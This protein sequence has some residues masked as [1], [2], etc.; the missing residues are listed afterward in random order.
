MTVDRR[1]IVRHWSGTFAVTID[2]HRPLTED[3]RSETERTLF[4]LMAD[5]EA[6][7]PEIMPVVEEIHAI[8]FGQRISF[9][10]RFDR[11]STNHVQK[12][13]RIKRDLEQ[14]VRTGRLLI[15]PEA[16]P[17]IRLAVT[18]ETVAAPDLRPAPEGPPTFFEVR[19][20]D[21]IGEAIADLDIVVSAEG[22]ANNL[23]TDSSGVARLDGVRASFASVRVASV[24]ALRDTVEPRWEALRTGE[25][26]IAEPMTRLPLTDSLGAISL[27]SARQHLVVIEPK[28]GKLLMQLLDKPG[29]ALH[30]ARP[31]RITGPASFEG[32]TDERGELLHQDVPPGDYELT[33]TVEV[34]VGGKTLSND[35]TSPA[36]VVPASEGRPIVRRL[37]ALPR[38]VMARIRG[39][40][41]QTNKCFLLPSAIPSLRRVRDVY[42]KNNPSELLVVG[43]TDTSGEP[44]IND[45]LSIER[46]D[47][48]AAFL[49]DDVEPWLDMYGTGKPESKRWGNAEDLLMIQ[50]M[51]DF[52]AKP[53]DVDPIRWFQTRHN[54]KPESQR[55]PLAS[56][57]V[58][59]IA[60]PNTRRQLAHDYMELDGATLGE[61]AGFD[62]K[63]TT[64]G[65]GENFPVDET[66]TELDT[67]PE[68]NRRDQLDRRVE[69][70]FFDAEFGIQPPP[71]G[72]NSRAGS[73]EYLEWRRRAEQEHLFDV[74]DQQRLLRLWVLLKGEPVKNAS[75]RLFVEGQLVG[76]GE[77]DGEG[78]LVQPVPVEARNGLL[79][80]PNVGLSRAISLLPAEV[81]PR[82]DT[83]QGQQSRLQQLGFYVGPL[84]GRKDVVFEEAVSEFRRTYALGSGTELDPPA[85]EKLAATYGS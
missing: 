22:K 28:R 54:D 9:A 69:L 67:A 12:S 68:D 4:V 53:P 62:I 29:R 21:E 81:F 6:R 57:K 30:V 24:Q 35:Y 52:G 41:F 66:G 2:P 32:E 74:E 56:L 80:L 58:D 70:F 39:L 73:T 14:A 44:S 10:P 84:D 5:H 43:H 3:E 13:E 11:D 63:I 27:E 31:Y 71:P 47:A 85:Q 38:V 60:G 77:T 75:F 1:R 37:G 33:L 55:R 20:V 82:V 40:L 25:P 45:P 59:G 17:V 51:P 65:C 23:K 46:A 64:H 79:V 18:E 83:V 42:V 50:T 15:V 19:F 76:A 34:E 48:V 72:K 26:P 8:L 49:K 7:D 36:V 61:D 78:I 16:R